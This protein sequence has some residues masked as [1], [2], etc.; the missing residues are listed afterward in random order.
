VGFNGAIERVRDESV[1]DEVT[2]VLVEDDAMVKEWVRSSLEGSEVRLVG[3]AG[4]VRTG[5]ELVHRRAPGLLLVDYRLPDGAGTDLVR[6]LRRER[7]DTPVVLMT[8]NPEPGLNEAAREA[9]AQGSVLKSGRIREVLEVLRRVAE[10]STSFDHRHP[11][12]PREFARLSPREREIVRL[13][14]NGL[15][16][17]EIAGR[18]EVGEETVKTMLSRACAKLGV[19]RRAEAVG[20]AHEQGIL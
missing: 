8:A 17:R 20:A 12:R 3:E 9:G 15:T 13:V 11:A 2:L 16:N 4:S 6:E 7:I 18:L 19:R 10:G 5:I 14:A 1:N